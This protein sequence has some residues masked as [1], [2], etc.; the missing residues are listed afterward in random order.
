MA[1]RRKQIR[2]IV[3]SLLGR[4]EI[5][6]AP[7]PVDKIAKEIGIQI[8]LDKVDA[9]L[10]GFI[11]RDKGKRALIGANKSHHPNRQRFTIAHELGH[12]FL[13]AGHTV[14]LD[15]GRLAYTVNLRNSDSSKGEDND[16]REANLFA[17]ELL[18]PAKFLRQ[19]LDGVELD[20]LEDSKFLSDLANKYRVSLQALTFRLTYLRYITE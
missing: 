8:K 13:H 7:I 1:V 20:L 6:R 9:D 10:S 2:E 4:H 3:E 11:V 12:Y 14:H 17:A 16:E 5:T 15:E 18:M 19:D